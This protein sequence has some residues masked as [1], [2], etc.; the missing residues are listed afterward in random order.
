MIE[1][2]MRRFETPQV[3][4]LRHLMQQPEFVEGNRVREIVDVLEDREFLKEALPR[5]L[6]GEQ[7]RALI[8]EENEAD[9]MQTCT[10]LVSRYGAPEGIGG[11]VGLLGPTRMEYRRSIGAVRLLSSMMS[12]LVD[13]LS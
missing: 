3:V 5:M 7:F 10:I 12:N 2:E 6:A 9:E 11:I 13:D 4:G 8:G 1:E